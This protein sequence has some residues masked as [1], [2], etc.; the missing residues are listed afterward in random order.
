MWENEIES[1]EIIN[2]RFATEDI[3]D[4]FGHRF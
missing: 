4:I 1:K 3:K 2:K